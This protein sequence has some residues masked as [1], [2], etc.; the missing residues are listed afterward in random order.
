MKIRVLSDLHLEFMANAGFVVPDPDPD[1]VLVLAGDIQLWRRRGEYL[2]FIG[3]CADQFRNVVVVGG[4]HE[5]YGSELQR[6]ISEMCEAALKFPGV[7]FLND[8]YV[9]IDGVLFVGSTLWTDFEGNNPI[10]RMNVSSGLND[11][12]MICTDGGARITPDYWLSMHNTSLDFI[13]C[14]L[15]QFPTGKRVVVTHHLPSNNSEP[16]RFRGS[17][18]SGGFASNL[19]DFI[20]DN[21]PDLWIHGHTHD[22]CDYNIG[23][24]R[25]VC[26][27]RGYPNEPS[28]G[29]DPL[30][31]VTI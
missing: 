18:V 16:S 24:T 15:D 4:N 7:Y 3:L 30:F 25:I 14:T 22:H 19:E 20:L 27:P 5:F 2:R 1:T 26:N 17:P 12:R 13:G 6:A 11:F 23:A 21:E 8:D 10:S 28:V 9:H 29:F 31:E